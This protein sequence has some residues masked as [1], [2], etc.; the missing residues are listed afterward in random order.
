METEGKQS[1]NN[2]YLQIKIIPLNINEIWLKLSASLPQICVY[3]EIFPEFENV[4]L[5]FRMNRVIAW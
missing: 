5:I 3:V 4:I 1:M 2:D